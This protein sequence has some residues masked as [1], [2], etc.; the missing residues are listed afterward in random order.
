MKVRR[1]FNLGR[2]DRK[3]ESIEFEV[4]GP[5]LDKLI[6]EIDGAWKAYCKAIVDGLVA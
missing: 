2:I 3:Y 1:K 6:M 5:D 4:E